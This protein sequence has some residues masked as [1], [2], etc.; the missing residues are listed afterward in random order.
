M[1]L[2]S[3]AYIP[4]PILWD[5]VA[6]LVLLEA[7]GCRALTLGNTGWD[8]LTCFSAAADGLQELAG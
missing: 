7:A 1:G 4:Q 2:L 3:F 6:G 8:P 5:V